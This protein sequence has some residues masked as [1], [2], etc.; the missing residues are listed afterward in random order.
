MDGESPMVNPV[1]EAA[2]TG[3]SDGRRLYVGNLSYA[4]TVKDLEDFFK[5][6]LL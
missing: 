6:Y 5:E 4:A 3:A 1:E 2:T